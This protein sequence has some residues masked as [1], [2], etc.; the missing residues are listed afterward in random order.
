MAL[1]IG[2]KAPDFSLPSTSGSPFRL[3]ETAKNKPC[4]LYFYPKDF[5]S[6]CTKESCEFRDHFEE[7]RGLN[8][9]V[10]GISFDDIPTHLKFKKVYNLPFELLADEDA[11]IAQLYGVTIPFTKMMRRTTYFLDD[12]HI[13]RAVY[14]KMLSSKEHVRRMM[15]AI[16]PE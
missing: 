14:T 16:K 12:Q 2:Q 4:I 10:Y 9:D 13:V 6:N 5:T 11:S 7:F 15:L 3:E 1:K 8:I